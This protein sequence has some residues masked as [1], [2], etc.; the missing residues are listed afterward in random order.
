VSNNKRLHKDAFQEQ[1]HS[2]EKSSQDPDI[3]IVSTDILLP[4]LPDQRDDPPPVPQ[5][6]PKADYKTNW[7]PEPEPTPVP[8][9]EPTIAPI[10]PPQDQPGPGPTPQP[11]DIST[12][13][14]TPIPEFVTCGGVQYPIRFKFATPYSLAYDDHGKHRL[15]PFFRESPYHPEGVPVVDYN[16][17][18]YYFT[19]KGNPL[20]LPSDFEGFGDARKLI[21]NYESNLHNRNASLGLHPESPERSE[22]DVDMEHSGQSSQ[23]LLWST[24]KIPQF[25]SKR[26]QPQHDGFT[27]NAVSSS[28]EEP[29]SC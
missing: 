3:N 6:P 16:G 12:T 5:P 13:L 4:Q 11:L 18:L 1:Q 15:V 19:S 7:I 24:T 28:I 22:D 27:A 9:L 21:T 17:I 8:Q 25:P 14:T 23:D 10:A 2:I 26:D 29:L 20:P